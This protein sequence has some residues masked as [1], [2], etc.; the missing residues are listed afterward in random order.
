M[1][2]IIIILALLIFIPLIGFSQSVQSFSGGIFKEVEQAETISTN[3][4]VYI[5]DLTAP[6]ITNNRF[7]ALRAPREKPGV[8]F[9]ASAIIPGAGQAANGKWVRAG[10]Y[11]TVEAVGIAY[12]LNRNAKAKRQERA[13]EQFTHQNWSVVAYASWLVDY[14]EHHGL[15]NGW[16]QLQANLQGKSPDFSNT[17]N[18]WSKV[19]LNLLQQ[20][21]RQTPF[22]FKDRI[23]SN[24]SH[25]LPEYGSQQ[26]YEL[27]SKYYQFQPGWKD[28]YNADPNRIS[29]LY[30]YSWNGQDEPITLFFEG[31]DRAAE[32]NQNYR[33]AG[34]ILKLLLVN[35][36]ISA[37][38]ALFTV[39]LKNSR[40][41]T[42]TNLLSSEQFSMTWHF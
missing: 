34:N 28:W 19:N 10:I 12:H 41:E 32:F 37:F 42:N 9:L 36:V 35:H 3:K 24:F 14:S 33:V 27:I 30:R 23:G 8:A 6:N 40:I 5:S 11:F 39:Q 4:Q 38:D 13:Y 1:K 18:D 16:Q 2:K 7:S 29:P 22:F 21:E 25:Q 20:V 26:Y 17:A 15:D 31:R